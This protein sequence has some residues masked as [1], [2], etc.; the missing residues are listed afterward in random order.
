MGIR[1]NNIFYYCK[2]IR[3]LLKYCRSKY[4]TS[5]KCFNTI[6]FRTLQFATGLLIIC[7]KWTLQFTFEE[8]SGHRHNK[9]TDGCWGWH[10]HSAETSPWGAGETGGR[11]A[12]SCHWPQGE[13]QG[14][15][16]DRTRRHFGETGN[17]LLPIMVRFWWVQEGV[18]L[19][20]VQEYMK[21]VDRWFNSSCKL[22]CVACEWCDMCQ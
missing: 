22:A 3:S 1:H 15:R 21:I 12:P 11:N 14:H 5:Y 8:S 10:R 2:Y 7:R 4:F 9:F 17:L 18:N 6:I 16:Q 19:L 20:A 13:R